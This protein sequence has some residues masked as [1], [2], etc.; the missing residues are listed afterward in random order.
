MKEFVVMFLLL[1]FLC[2]QARAQGT[3]KITKPIEGAVFA[4]G[5]KVEVVV[6]ALDGLDAPKVL[7]GLGGYED[8]ESSTFPVTTTFIIPEN[9]VGEVSVNAAAKA[10]NG[11]LLFVE[12]KIVVRPAAQL[13]KLIV[14][15]DAV[16]FTTNW[17][18]EI[19]PTEDMYFRVEGIYADGV[20][21]EIT[22]FGTTYISGD[23]SVVSIKGNCMK[24]EKDGKTVITVT[25]GSA[26]VDVP[27]S[28]AKPRGIPPPELVR[29]TTTASVTPTPGA[30]GLI[31]GQATVTLKATDN[32]GGTG[33]R[34]I[35]YWIPGIS[36]RD[37]IIPG[38]TVSFVVSKNGTTD[39]H[40][41]AWDNALNMEDDNILT[42]NI[43]NEFDMHLSSV[44]GYNSLDA[45]IGNSGAAVSKMIIDFLKPSSVDGQDN[46]IA[47]ADKDAS[48][49]LEADELKAVLNDKA[50]DVYNFSL[51]TDLTQWIDP[52]KQEDCLSQIAHWLTYD[53]PNTAAGKNHVP[54][55]VCTSA[56]PAVNADSDYKHWMS[57]VGVKANQ[58]PAPML[59]GESAIAVPSS[60]ALYGFYVNDPNATGLGF[61]TYT[62]IDTWNKT[63]FRPIASGL[64]YAGNYIAVMEPPEQKSPP[65]TLVPAQE[66]AGLRYQLNTAQSSAS[67]FV[68]GYV[69][70][71]ARTYLDGMLKKLSESSDFAALLDDG[72]FGQTMKDALVRRCYKVDG[73]ATDDYTIIPFE[74]EVQGRFVT[75]AAVLVD[76]TTGSFQLAGG[77]LNAKTLFE[78]VGWL[79]A[80]KKTRLAAGWDN[81]ALVD[82]RLAHLT[83][84]PLVPGWATRIARIDT[85]DGVKIVS[86]DEYAV[87][88]QGEI[89]IV[90]KAPEVTVKDRAV[91]LDNGTAVTMIVFSVKA[92]GAYQVTVGGGAESYVKR[93]G[94]TWVA[95]VKSESEA[96]AITLG[97]TV[98]R[99][100]A[101]LSKDGN[102][103]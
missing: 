61:H 74:K 3:M 38:D 17:A 6:E 83:G 40:Y 98:T 21:R 35:H 99:L 14:T 11:D 37:I 69:D 102:R 94:D 31:A 27:V 19:D 36:S 49:A 10:K 22:Q 39:V 47:Y 87:S 55:A 89:R 100:Y 45:K 42:L 34:E 77:D 62:A 71:E 64:Q 9:V 51:T 97:N 15:P 7:V 48:G 72:Y 88:A 67:I 46:L 60:L 50:P 59:A 28:V 52:T 79:G 75:T 57:L 12:N 29:P 8:Y 92:S 18:G 76:N 82:W 33:V 95:L 66:N 1:F 53:L 2:G 32:A 90:Y 73:G 103:E 20:T 30:D 101:C 24:P 5:E 93:D 4:P 65:V 96:V 70:Q 16:S 84:S 23:P 81:A 44:Q 85:K 63:Y 25:N 43:K 13:V 78:P 68:P 91:Y 56:D 80:Y 58:N 54:V 26:R 86:V 41:S